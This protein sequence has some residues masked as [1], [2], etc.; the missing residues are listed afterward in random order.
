MAN[1]SDDTDAQG[2]EKSFLATTSHEI[3]TPLNGILGTVSLLLETELDHAQREYAESI[4]SS[5]SQLLDLLN[6]VLDYARLD[7]DEVDIDTELLNPLEIPQ[8]VAELLSPRAHGNNLDIAVRIL[9]G[10]PTQG[11]GDSGRI[12]QILFNLVGNALKFTQTGGV[13]IDVRGYE[14][15][16][17][18]S[19]IDSGPGI[20][21]DAMPDLFSAFRQARTSDAQRESGVGLGL[22]IVRRICDAVGGRIEVTSDAGIGA[23]FDVY[24]PLAHADTGGVRAETDAVRRR[25]GLIDLPPATTLSVAADIAGLGFAPLKMSA[26]EAVKAGLDLVIVSADSPSETIKALSA[27][28]KTLVALR[29]RDRGALPAFRKLGCAGW[30]VRPSRSVSV[31]DR[32]RKA[33]AGQADKTDEETRKAPRRTCVL[34]ADDNQVNALIARRALEVSGFQTRVAQTGSDAVET[35]LREEIDLVLMD[36]R[37]PVMDGFE[38]MSR[39]R[40]SGFKAPII[41]IS[42]EMTSSIARRARAAGANAVASKPVDPETLR[43]IALDW[44]DPDHAKGAA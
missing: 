35:A 22:A 18:Y 30:I 41:A 24:I 14:D 1:S 5:G 42:A 32:V 40:G 38:A 21:A 36:L 29:P 33:L 12:R 2:L 6:N 16:V 3:R 39:L 27:A 25:V 8:D 17:R 13:L 19:V 31:A 34:I 44:T 4:R 11:V 15:G 10:A 7:A 26:E 28:A 37:M 43:S 23:R 20:P 9:P